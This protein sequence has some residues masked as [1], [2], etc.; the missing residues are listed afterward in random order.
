MK[1]T[2][3]FLLLLICACSVTK[4]VPPPNNEIAF[5]THAKPIKIF[6]IGYYRTDLMIL[7]L[8]DSKDQYFTIEA[9]FDNA[10]RVGNVYP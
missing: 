2:L 3:F 10:L 6:G 5:E 7:T 4:N 9:P 1:T 8:V